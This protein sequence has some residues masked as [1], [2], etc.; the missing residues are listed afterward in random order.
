MSTNMCVS[1][2]VCTFVRISSV[3]YAW[4]LKWVST[5]ESGTW[6]SG[7]QR[8][9]ECVCTSESVRPVE[10]RRDRVRDLSY[11]YTILAVDF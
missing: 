6:E 7:V 9:E 2:S 11:T 4:T 10:G 5:G 3:W 8:D 1:K